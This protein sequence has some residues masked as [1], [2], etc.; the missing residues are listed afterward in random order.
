MRSIVSTL[1]VLSKGPK[2]IETRRILR[3]IAAFY[4]YGA[5]VHVLNMLSLTG[6]NWG[7]AP[8]KWQAL[9]VAYLILDVTVAVGLLRGTRIGV[10]AF[11]C[12]ACSQIV[13]YTVFRNWVLDVPD[14]F[15]RTREEIAYL[16]SL[17]LFHLVTVAI[18][19]TVMWW[20]RAEGRTQR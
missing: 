6:F 12:A 10:W 17:V 9:D 16:D 7:E 13:L 19:T 18:V 4:A 11:Y 14:A 2:P 8:A 3:I 20:G 5:L 15:Q 1:N